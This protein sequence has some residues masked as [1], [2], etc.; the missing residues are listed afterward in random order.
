MRIVSRAPPER[1]DGEKA[2]YLSGFAC[3]RCGCTIYQYC[4]LE[5]EGADGEQFL[6]CPPCRDQLNTMGE[7][8]AS[9]LDVLRRSPLPRQAAFDRRTLPYAQGHDIP[10]LEFPSG[11]TMR[12]T[13]V[14]ILLAGK[15]VLSLFPPIAYGGPAQMTIALG[16]D[17]GVPTAIVEANMWAPPDADW[18]FDRRGNR[19]SF[20]SAD[21]AARLSLAFLPDSV[22]RIEHLRC[23]FAGHS[24]EID[25]NGAMLNG[26]SV[27]IP[28]SEEQLVGVRLQ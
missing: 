8:L 17:S 14:P 21:R 24:L 19:Y 13:A 22:I 9:V 4:S 20:E 10:D 11:V 2:R 23:R 16:D 5:S 27:V 28:D 3:I 1:R 15:S 26:R 12:Q 18:R 6:L 7:R 25:E